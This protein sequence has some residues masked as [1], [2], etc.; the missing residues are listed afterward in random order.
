MRKIRE[1]ILHWLLGSTAKSWEEM[2]HITCECHAS[3]KQMID[4]AG[5][6][7]EEYNK[8]SDEYV[9]VLNMISEE[10]DIYNLKAKVSRFLNEKRSKKEEDESAK[11]E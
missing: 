2:F 1:W 8:V 9:T 10:S 6:L 7:L 4:R 5:F 3:S 11:A